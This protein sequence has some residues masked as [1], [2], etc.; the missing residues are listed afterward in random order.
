MGK[1]PLP[2]G[3]STS[4]RCPYLSSYSSLHLGVASQ[5]PHSLSPS[6]H[7]GG[8]CIG[9]EKPQQPRGPGLLGFTRE[10]QDVTPSPTNTPRP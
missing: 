10:Q 9:L 2:R 8:Q 3:L 7:G 5:S 1:S 4:D 6:S